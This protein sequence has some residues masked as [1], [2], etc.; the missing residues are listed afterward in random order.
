MH[1]SFVLC[2]RL[3]QFSDSVELTD[4]PFSHLTTIACSATVCT[5]TGSHAGNLELLGPTE[6]FPPRFVE[7]NGA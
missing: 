6:E 1:S 2:T 7:S 4:S 3:R 5:S